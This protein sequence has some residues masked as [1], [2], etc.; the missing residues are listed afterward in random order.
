VYKENG[1][2]GIEFIDKGSGFSQLALKNLYSF[3]G[4]GDKHIDENTGLNLAL[5]KLIMNAHEGDI[6]V[7]NNEVGVTVKLIFKN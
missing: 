4:V 3:F 2:T 5:V 7:S 6:I 1:Y